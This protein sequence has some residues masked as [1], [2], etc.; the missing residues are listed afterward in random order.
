MTTTEGTGRQDTSALTPAQ[1]WDAVG[2]AWERGAAFVE[3]RAGRLTSWMLAAAEVASG[4]EVLDV[5]CG[6]GGAGLAAAERVGPTGRV[7]L[8]DVSPEMARIAA[9]QAA[10]RGLTWAHGDVVDASDLD[11]EPG[12]QYDAVLSRDGVQFAA[13]PH[14]A[15]GGMFHV[16]KPGG[17]LAVA[18]WG[19]PQ[20]NPWLGLI[21]RAA[22]EVLGRP[23]APPGA[24]GP[25]SLA[26]RAELSGLLRGA[27]FT[28]VRLEEMAAPMRPP[29][30]QDWVNRAAS[31]SGP[32]AALARTVPGEVMDRINAPAM[33]LATPFVT[34]DGLA[35]PGLAVLASARRPA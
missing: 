13:D 31:L 22:T 32:I 14:R 18:V 8:S 7:V 28:E 9:G 17:R 23:V 3:H 16:L 6:P 20:E 21:M 25:F 19:T 11:A 2:P 12:E 15:F 34:D 4:D 10:A 29:S 24:R 35:L 27:G 1:M 26:D 5:G 33:E 30:L